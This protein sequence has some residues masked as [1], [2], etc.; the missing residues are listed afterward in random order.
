MLKL[1]VFGF[2]YLLSMSSNVDDENAKISCDFDKFPSLIIFDTY[3]MFIRLLFHRTNWKREKREKQTTLHLWQA[4]KK[5]LYNSER[6]TATMFD[7]DL[8]NKISE[9]QR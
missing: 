9:H 8:S 3:T 4:Y 5:K 1:N 2:E 7:I 6:I